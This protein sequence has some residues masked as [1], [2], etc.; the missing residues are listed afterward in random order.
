MHYKSRKQGHEAQGCIVLCCCFFV[1]V[2][3]P[4]FFPIL[5]VKFTFLCPSLQKAEGI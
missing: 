5:G 1:L 4:Y 2:F 3:S